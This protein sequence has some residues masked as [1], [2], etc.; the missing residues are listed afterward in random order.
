MKNKKPRFTATLAIALVS[1]FGVL[2]Q[3]V[4]SGVAGAIVGAFAVGYVS[5][6]FEAA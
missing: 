1:A 2:A 4:G 6:W 5:A 3:Y